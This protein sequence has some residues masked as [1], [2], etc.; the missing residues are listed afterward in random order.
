MPQSGY[1]VFWFGLHHTHKF[2]GQSPISGPSVTHSEPMATLTVFLS[3]S[4]L[5]AA[6]S[7]GLAIA[8]FMPFMDVASHQFQLINHNRYNP[9]HAVG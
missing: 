9:D 3:V 8:A 7:S 5:K 2:Q 4:A 1:L 6:T